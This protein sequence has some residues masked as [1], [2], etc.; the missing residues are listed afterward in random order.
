M[1]NSR[2]EA[3]GYVR[4]DEL[5]TLDELRARLKLGDSAMR[6]ARRAGLRLLTVG[7]RRYVSGRQLIEWMES[8]GKEIRQ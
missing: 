2:S 5:Y 6:Q 1:S 8:H 7:R 4:A 3:P